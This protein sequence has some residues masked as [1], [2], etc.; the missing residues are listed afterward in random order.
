[1]AKIMSKIKKIFIYFLLATLGGGVSL[2][3]SDFHDNSSSNKLPSN[4]VS[5]LKLLRSDYDFQ[6]RTL[7]MTGQS[8]L[9]GKYLLAIN[10]AEFKGESS[11]G[12]IEINLPNIHLNDLDEFTLQFKSQHNKDILIKGSL[13]PVSDGTVLIKEI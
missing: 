7:T 2:F 1:M 4:L 13:S 12:I 11:K 9:K 10:G 3:A 5:E 8:N 6:D